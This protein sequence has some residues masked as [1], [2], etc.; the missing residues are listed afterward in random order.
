MVRRSWRGMALAVVVIAPVLARVQEQFPLSNPT[1]QG[2]ETSLGGTATLDIIVLQGTSPSVPLRF[3]NVTP[4]SERVEFNGRVLRKGTDYAMDYAN[5]V[6]FLMRAQ[7]LGQ[8]LTV[9]Y[10]YDKS[11]PAPDQQ[12]S[13]GFNG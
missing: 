5:G 12:K 10:R 8:S 6:V 13:M 2:P 4:G 3:G 7:R 11:K 9:S 1:S